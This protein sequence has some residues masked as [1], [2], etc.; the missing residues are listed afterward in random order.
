[1]LEIT[2]LRQPCPSEPWITEGHTAA[3]QDN[4]DGRGTPWI[5]SSFGNVFASDSQG[6]CWLIFVKF[7]C[8]AMPAQ[9][10]M[11]RLDGKIILV[12]AAAQGIG[13]AAAIVSWK[14][15]VLLCLCKVSHSSLS[16]DTCTKPVLEFINHR[17]GQNYPG[18]NV[19]TMLFHPGFVLFEFMKIFNSWVEMLDKDK[20]KN[21]GQLQLLL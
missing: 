18:N 10:T 13:Q 17:W 4:C 19:A 20:S 3:K 6:W 9:V 5:M 15:F 14:T 16:N 8:H 11:G 1:M 7:L 21:W 2:R 12:S